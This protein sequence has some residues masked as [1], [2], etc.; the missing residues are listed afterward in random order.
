[1][2]SARHPF[3]NTCIALSIALGHASSTNTAM[4]AGIPVIDGANLSQNLVSAFENVTQTLKQI[5]QYKTQLDQYRNMLQNTAA[6]AMYIWDQARKTMNDLRTALDTLQYYKRTLGNINT[7]LGQFKTPAAYRSS[8]CFSARGCSTKDWR[9]LH[10]SQ[11]LG[12]E[13]QKRAIDAMLR[14]VDHQ[15]DALQ[16][17]AQ[18]L[19]RLQSNAQG[20]KGQMEALAYASQLASQQS[21]QL[22]QIRALLI[23]QQ[24][25]TAA[26]YQALADREALARASD[27]ASFKSTYKASTPSNW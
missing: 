7:Y 8:P 18:Q 1:M 13:S 22:L 25:M 9:D 27:E 16:A 12:A 19:Q 20:A 17:D 15:Q 26:R 23:A 14:T 2:K 4:A 6:P 5:Q 21:N 11:D 10:A 3:L 24:N